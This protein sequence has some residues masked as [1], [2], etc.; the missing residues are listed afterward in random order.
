MRQA[1]TVGLN[2]CR[3][4]IQTML[5]CLKNCVFQLFALIIQLPEIA[6]V[7]FAGFD[8]LGYGMGLVSQVD[9]GDIFATGYLG[10]VPAQSS[11]HA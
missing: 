10:Q 9:R 6:P 7:L 1:L 8:G 4:V 3:Q 5:G 2:E 11:V